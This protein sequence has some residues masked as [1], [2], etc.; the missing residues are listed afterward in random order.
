M[1]VIACLKHIGQ[2]PL[3]VVNILR[4]Q[5]GWEKGKVKLSYA[6]RL[7][8]MAHGLMLVLKDEQCYKQHDYHNLNKK[9]IFKMLVGISTDTYD[10]LGKVDK[11][12][13]IDNETLI[14]VINKIREHP[15]T[16]FQEYPPYSS[17]RVDGKPLWKHSKDGTLDLITIPGK[18]VSIQCIGIK[19]VQS[20]NKENLLKLIN[21]NIGKMDA[22]HNFRQ[23]EILEEWP[24]INEDDYKVITIVAEVSCGFYVRSF[25]HNIGESLGIPCMALDI[26]RTQVG[27]Y[28]L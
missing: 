11:V 21:I 25:C 6:G 8:P 9:Y 5:K 17:V 28:H 1:S 19:G 2:T 15:H 22:K 10:I 12:M 7:D 26:L 13:N 27:E 3:E 20:I 23:K 24:N 14:E 4:E 16:F 18:K